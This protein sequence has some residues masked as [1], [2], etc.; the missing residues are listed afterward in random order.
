MFQLCWRGQVTVE[1][2]ERLQGLSLFT[3][4][5]FVQVYEA[6]NAQPVADALGV[7]PAKISRCL[8]S[9]RE[10]T[11]D[12]LFVRR[13]SRLEA[14][15]V[16]NQLYPG[17]AQVLCK[18]SQVAMQLETPN[19]VESR[20]LTIL[21]PAPL[22]CRLGSQLKKRADDLGQPVA[23]NI[24]PLPLVGGEASLKEDGQMLIQCLPSSRENLQSRFIATG[25]QFFVVARASHPIWRC[26]HNNTLDGMLTFPYLITECP[27]YVDRLDPL[28]R[29]AL[30]SGRKLI[31][32]G[33]VSALSEVSDGLLE[34]D[35]F[36][37]VSSRMA[38]DFLGYIPGLKTRRL[39]DAEFG[40]LHHDITPPS[41]YLITRSEAHGIPTWLTNAIC[42]LVAQSVCRTSEVDEDGSLS[43]LET[44]SSL[45][46]KIPPVKS[47]CG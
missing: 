47:S 34:S 30:S 22:T 3:I 14:T 9:L 10:I 37:L 20:R 42:E 1:A 44:L 12:P 5:V 28:E 16:A 11:G 24:Q 36:T 35:A 4:R 33:R 38:S 41:Y 40:L 6:H 43:Y 18:A 23:L 8:A 27:A 29:Y 7:S 2:I 15:P 17:L 45:S 19:E 46:F 32:A 25:E 13:H 39:S 31:G 26:P 21:G